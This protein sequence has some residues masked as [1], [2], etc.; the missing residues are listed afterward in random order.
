MVQQ[1]YLKQI[2]NKILL[3]TG[4]L[5]DQEADHNILFSKE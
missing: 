2:I 1:E 3:C 5:K 4:N